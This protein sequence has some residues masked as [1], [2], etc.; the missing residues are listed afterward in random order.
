M[1][2]FSYGIPGRWRGDSGSISFAICL[3]P[4]STAASPV[5]RAGL[6]ACSVS[7]S[8]DCSSARVLRLARPVTR[9]PLTE[10]R[11]TA[12]NSRVV[13]SPS[14]GSSSASLRPRAFATARS[15]APM[16]AWAPS[17]MTSEATSIDPRPACTA[18]LAAVRLASDARSAESRTAP[19][20]RSIFRV[21]IAQ[22]PGVAFSGLRLFR[23]TPSVRT[24]KHVV[25]GAT[26]GFT[27]SLA[28]RLVRTGSR[29]SSAEGS[30]C[31][32]L[33]RP[34]R[35]YGQFM[36]SGQRGLVISIPMT[37]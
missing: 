25:T 11:S 14:S 9:R 35:G 4:R 19:A 6:I 23:P 8:L 22:P 34:E 37:P 32:G 30:H 20:S 10:R 5:S 27:G 3:P 26:P 1:V 16:T 36:R 12:V 2:R 33:T 17:E 21:V 29:G 7:D 15:T 18:E 24:P 31:V 28:S 13:N